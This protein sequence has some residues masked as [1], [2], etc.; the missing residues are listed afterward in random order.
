MIDSTRSVV[1][2][3]NVICFAHDCL[4]DN[5][6]TMASVW[7]SLM[8]LHP[9]F[10]VAMLL[11]VTDKTHKCL[12]LKSTVLSPTSTWKRVNLKGSAI[13][14]F[15]QK[16]LAIFEVYVSSTQQICHQCAFSVHWLVVHRYTFQTHNEALWQLPSVIVVEQ[17][18]NNCNAGV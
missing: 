6:I 11:C 2:A 17:H 8:P 1:L 3:S 13:L 12:T 14:G 18:G 16:L 4:A 7:L 5:L 15:L 10:N 9:V